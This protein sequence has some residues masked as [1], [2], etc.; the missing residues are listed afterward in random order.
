MPAAAAAAH[1]TPSSPWSENENLDEGEEESGEDE[2]HTSAS[3]GSAQSEDEVPFGVA[4]WGYVTLHVVVALFIGV[5]LRLV[6]FPQALLADAT[7]ADRTDFLIFFGVAKAASDFVGGASADYWGR[8]P[9]CIMG[10]LLGLPLVVV[11]YGAEA[12][13]SRLLLDLSD[14]LLGAMQ[15]ITWGLN[16]IFLMDILGP[17]G[18]GLASALSNAAGYFGSAATAPLAAALVSKAGNASLCLGSLCIGVLF[19]LVLVVMDRRKERGGSRIAAAIEAKAQVGATGASVGG[20]V[21]LPARLGCGNSIQVLCM[22]AGHTVNAATAL[23]WGATVQ[24]M[25][26]EGDISVS[27]IAIVESWFTGLKVVAMLIS[28]LLA[29]RIRPRHIVAVSMAAMSTGLGMLAWQADSP[30]ASLHNLLCA[31]GLL[32]LGVGGAY[33]ALAAAVTEGVPEDRRASIY[34]AYRMWRDLGFASGGLFTRLFSTFASEVFGVFLWSTVVA[35]LFLCQ[36]AC[37]KGQGDFELA[38]GGS[39]ST[40]SETCSE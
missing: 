16:I 8:K 31:T 29:Y 15:G 21:S 9:T 34:G 22:L 14:M 3:A 27:D 25:K 35:M 39:R 18:R 26:T 10:W 36:L 19:G 37:A 2:H 40:Q 28:G 11:L 12:L 17:K 24:W 20:I 4:K 33:P 6:L 30:P 13:K 23:I 1:A 5:N 7:K 38:S 32:G